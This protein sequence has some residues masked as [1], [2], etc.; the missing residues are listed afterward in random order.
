MIAHCFGSFQILHRCKRYS[1]VAPF[2]AFWG[3]ASLVCA[4]PPRHRSSASGPQPV[5]GLM[6]PKGTKK[7]VARGGPKR[8][9][10]LTKA[11]KQA[12]QVQ[13][14]QPN[15][16]QA[17]LDH[18]L[19]LEEDYKHSPE[20]DVWPRNYYR[21][22]QIS[23][24]YMLTVL[25]QCAPGWKDTVWAKLRTQ[26]ALSDS[27]P[28]SAIERLCYWAT[29]S[30]PDNVLI[31]NRVVCTKV[32]VDRYQQF[33]RRLDSV[34]FGDNGWVDWHL[35]GYFT[36]EHDEAGKVTNI[37][38]IS[39]N[40]ARPSARVISLPVFCGRSRCFELGLHVARM[41]GVCL[42]VSRCSEL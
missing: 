30:N 42:T 14:T 5:L 32:L 28:L 36:F 9:T 25:R 22:K 15:L 29:A 16:A 20:N 33:G 34:V 6:A 26:P 10:A 17:I 8:D 7:P 19:K 1:K 31:S 18:A 38:H 4:L 12:Q 41:L 27:D 39:G 37:C 2:V 40:K 24:T 3:R 13:I 21:L 11:G 23:V 35:C